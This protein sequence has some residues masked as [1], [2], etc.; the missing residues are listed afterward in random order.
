MIYTLL[1]RNRFS[2]L[3]NAKNFG[4]SKSELKIIGARYSTATTT[5]CYV[6]RMDV[7]VPL[8]F[9]PIGKDTLNQIANKQQSKSAHVTKLTLI[10]FAN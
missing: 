1:T 3:K 2:K 6:F 10:G 5:K 7:F 8:Y 4:K 9:V